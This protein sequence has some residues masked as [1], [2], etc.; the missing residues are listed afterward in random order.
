MSE[1][2]ATEI[3]KDIGNLIAGIVKKADVVSNDL[4]LQLRELQILL[5]VRS[6]ISFLERILKRFEGP[7]T[8]LLIE[9]YICP[10]CTEIE[11]CKVRLSFD[12]QIEK[13]WKV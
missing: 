7:V 12:Q 10:F 8:A 4:P 1:E 5:A 6:T 2:F 13:V 9:S 11:T 3:A